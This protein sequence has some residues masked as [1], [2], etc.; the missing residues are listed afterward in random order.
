M[1]ET[2]SR[3]GLIAPLRE[4]SGPG[5]RATICFTNRSR[6]RAP[7][8]DARG[9]R[10]PELAT[11]HFGPLLRRLRLV[12]ALSQEELAERAGLS[13]RG[14]SALETGHR[15]TPRP[16]TVRLL[17]EALGLDAATRAE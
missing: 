10:M 5:G 15:A 14:I 4:G 8:A 2:V 16:E 1:S 12:A 13:A 9:C 3:R 17:A 6:H 7:A 11:D